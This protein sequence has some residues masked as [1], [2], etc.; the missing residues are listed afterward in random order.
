MPEKRV[1]LSLS[2][3]ILL[4]LGLGVVVGLFFGE[5]ASVLQPLADVY[6]RL[7]QMTVLPYLVLAL[8]IGFGQLDR[9]T[10]RRLA[11]R[12]GGLLV[13]IW[14]LTCLVIFAMPLTFPEYESASFFSHALVEPTRSFDIAELYFTA[15][16]FHSLANAVIPAIVLFS[17]MIGIGLIG[18]DNREHLL[19]T[20]RVVNEAVVRITKFIVGLTPIGVFAI[21]A[22]TAGTMTGET[23]QRL[24][25]YFITFAAAALLLTFWILP[26]LVTAATPFSYREVIRVSRDAMLTAFVANNAFIVLPILVERSKELLRKHDLAD[27]QSESAADVL[28]PIMFNFPNAGRLLTLLFIPFAAWLAGDALGIGRYPELFLIGV[29]SYFAKAQVALPFLLDYLGLPH[30]LFQLYIPTTIIGGKFD[31]MVTAMNLLVFALLG[32]AAMAGFLELRLRRLLRAGGLILAGLV[33]TVIAVSMTLATTVDTT[34]HQDEA[35][36]RMH[37]P[38]HDATPTVHRDRTALA[39][40]EAPV[41]LRALERIRSRGTLRIGYDPENLPF[42]FFNLDDELVGLD[43]ELS[44]ELADALGVQAEFVPVSWSE[45]GDELDRGLIDVMPGMWYRPFWFDSLRLSEPYFTATVGIVVPDDRRHDFATIEAIREQRGLRIGVPLDIRQ[46]EFALDHYFGGADVEFVTVKPSAATF[47]AG[48][49]PDLDGFVMPAE[50]GAAWTLIHPKFT[51][52]VPQPEPVKLP[53][54]FGVAR[55]ADDLLAVVDEWVV[56]ANSEGIPDRAYRY[57]ILGRGAEATGRRWSILHDV[58]GWGEG[59]SDGR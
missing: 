40:D 16:P 6:I 47:F 2:A 10:A 35:L 11:L 49:V 7:M 26:L 37:A 12:G 58:L 50:S 46:L 22:V 52:V 8:V 42:S 9:D 33:V 15:N 48:S 45:L 20:L 24:Q 59:D 14:G 25:V 13:I 3:Q 56:Y 5:G 19:S 34:Y 44:L 38:R 28:I 1:R 57:W 53:T 51:V 55:G 31:S 36:R 29:S 27:A 54:A 41:G 39:L 32:A 43:V 18:L 17:S 23:L 4:G 21:G 30:D